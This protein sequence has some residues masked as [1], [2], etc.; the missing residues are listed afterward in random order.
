MWISNLSK[1]ILFAWSLFIQNQVLATQ[2]VEN[3]I[4]WIKNDVSNQIDVPSEIYKKSL[5][6][7][8]EHEMMFLKNYFK[9]ETEEDIKLFTMKLQKENHLK[10]DWVIWRE[11]LKIIYLKYYKNDMTIENS[12]ILKRLKI[13][14]EMLWYSKYKKAKY[15]SLNVFDHMAYYWDVGSEN[16]TWTFINE[17]LFYILPKN[18]KQ[19]W[20]ILKTWI[21]NWKHV[22]VFYINHELYLA[23]YISPGEPL[24]H[25]S[26]AYIWFWDRE[27]DKYH[28]SSSYPE[29][30]VVSYDEFWNE[31]TKKV[32]IWWSVMPY[33]VN[34]RWSEYFHWSD[35]KINWNWESSWCSRTPLFYIYEIYNKVQELW[36]NN[37]TIDTTMMYSNLKIDDEEIMFAKN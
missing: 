34:I 17:E 14:N 24:K 27:L 36:K 12:D 35:H 5:D 25:K 7:I 1:S 30:T 10:Q 32:P 6:R 4:N 31:T 9:L 23:S 15:K 22:V 37:V 8:W 19:D 29:E 13:Y 20:N 11:T 21:I 33:A 18:I 26:W 3:T 2:T 16:M 28:I